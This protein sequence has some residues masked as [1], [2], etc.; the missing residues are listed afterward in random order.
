M[1]VIEATYTNT[2]CPWPG[3]AVCFRLLTDVV[4][5]GKVSIH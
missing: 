5:V 4:A 1:N 2:G 3:G